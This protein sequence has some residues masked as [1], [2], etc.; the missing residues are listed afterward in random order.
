M[1]R[2]GFLSDCRSTQYRLSFLCLSILPFYRVVSDSVPNKKKSWCGLSAKLGRIFLNSAASFSL[3]TLAIGV[4]L[5]KCCPSPNHLSGVVVFDPIVS[6]LSLSSAFLP[7]HRLLSLP[8]AFESLS[9]NIWERGQF[10]SFTLCF[11]STSFLHG[12]VT[13]PHFLLLFSPQLI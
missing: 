8:H 1:L 4:D 3:L 12:H 5:M 9:S 6:S 11:S 2:I 13:G 10:F 7:L